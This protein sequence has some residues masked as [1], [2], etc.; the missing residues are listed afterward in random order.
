M[1]SESSRPVASSDIYPN[2][3]IQVK[4]RRRV[5]LAPGRKHLPPYAILSH[6]WILE[7]EI[8]NEDFFMYSL[9]QRPSL[10]LPDLQPA[11]Y[12]REISKVRTKLNSG[13]LKISGACKQAR[14]DGIKY[15]WVDT[16]CIEQGNH[17]D[18]KKNITSMYAYYQ[19]A[20][21][22]YVYLADV[23]DKSGMFWEFGKQ[24]GSEWFQRGWTLQELLAPRNVVFFNKYWERIGDKHELLDGIYH[25]TT[26]PRNVISGECSIRDIDVM[27]RMSWSIKRTTTR[28]QDLAYCLQGLLGVTVEP[29]YEEHHFTSFNR[30]GKTLLDAHPAFF[31]ANPELK[32]GLF[33]KVNDSYFWKQANSR[34]SVTRVKILDE[35]LQ[36]RDVKD[37]KED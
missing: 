23:E 20:Q 13:G 30:L 29:D 35:V 9:L 11:W 33:Q 5:K 32:D 27:T 8:N 18:V 12:Q 28:P 25:T 2:C 22:C 7:K 34:F 4:E 31:D 15:L 3:L 24:L 37:S 1:A 10:K 6:R 26:I 36:L 14:R 21:V 16:C 17:A 19:N